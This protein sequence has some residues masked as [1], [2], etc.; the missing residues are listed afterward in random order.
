[1][2]ACSKDAIMVYSDKVVIFYDRCSGCGNCVTVCPVGAM[3][4][5]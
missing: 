4:K 1:V 5:S 3:T 2:A